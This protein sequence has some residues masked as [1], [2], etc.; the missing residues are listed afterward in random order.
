M[1]GEAAL[2]TGVWWM[3]REIEL[4]NRRLK[5][6]VLKSGRGYGI[7]TLCVAASKALQPRR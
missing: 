3:R 4:A 1:S 2:V 7:A 5:D 6:V